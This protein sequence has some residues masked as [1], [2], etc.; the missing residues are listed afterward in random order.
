MDVKLIDNSFDKNKYNAKATSPLQSWEWGEAKQELG[1]Q[2]V[3]LGEFSGTE[4]QNV[5]Q[6]TIH[7]IPKTPYN[8]AYLPRSVFPSPE[9]LQFMKKFAEEKKILF[10]KLEPNIPK[11]EAPKKLPENVVRSGH[12][13][14]PSWT[15]VLDLRST[16]EE[17]LKNLKSKTR[18]NI[19]LAEKKGVHVEEESNEEGFKKFSKLYFET[20]KRQKY[21]GHDKH[22]HQVVWD[23]MKNGYAHILIAYFENTPLASYELFNFNKVLYYPYGGSSDQYRNLMGAN[24]LMWESIKL[25]KK[26]G[27]EKYDMFGSLSPE[28]DPHDPWAGFTRFKEGYN[29]QFYEFAGTYDLVVNPALYALYGVLYKARTAFLKLRA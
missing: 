23:H 29:T 19:R 11:S 16:E 26:L 1:N 8:V 25:G 3:R 18:Y 21:F 2:V 5:F 10:I 22:Y 4:L 12:P 20:T 15:Q 24:L 28:Y 9:T 7:S 6:F 17:L 13:L 14:F 27:A